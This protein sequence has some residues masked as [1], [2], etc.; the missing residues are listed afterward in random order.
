[1]SQSNVMA[2][3]RPRLLLLAAFAALL[4]A[5][6]ATTSAP[7]TEAALVE[8]AQARWDALLARDW[9]AAYALYSPGYRSSH[10]RTDFEIHYRTQRIKYLSASYRDHQ[11]EGEVCTVNFDL[12]YRAPRPV[13]GINEWKGRSVAHESWIRASGEWWYVPPK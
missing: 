5:S 7:G 8:R 4:T 11:C 3:P 1:M 9:D 6:C 10:S 12:E 13:P 2:T